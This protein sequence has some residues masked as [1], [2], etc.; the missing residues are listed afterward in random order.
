[1]KTLS[2]NLIEKYDYSQ[3]KLS[4]YAMYLTLIEIEN[5][6][7]EIYEADGGDDTIQIYNEEHNI[8]DFEPRDLMKF[9][10]P[11]QCMSFHYSID[12]DYDKALKIYLECQALYITSDENIP[13]QG[14]QHDVYEDNDDIDHDPNLSPGG[15][16]QP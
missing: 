4:P 10:T 6:F 8:W 5:L 1:M 11:N 14:K 9:L 7:R 13:D 15:Y 3:T 2:Q 16:F 12:E